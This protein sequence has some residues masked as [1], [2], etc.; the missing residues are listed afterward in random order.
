MVAKA[1]TIKTLA[2]EF[3]VSPATVSKAL[4]DS[5]DISEETKRKIKKLA[6]D[7]GYKPNLMARNLVSR[8]SNI[9]GIIVPNISTS[10]FG[11]T[12]RGIN[13]RSRKYSYETIILVND[14]DYKEERKNIEFLS[15]LQVEGIIIDSVPGDHNIDLLKDLSEKGMP[16]VF[17]DRK[18]DQVNAESVTTNDVKAGYRITRHFLKNKKK[19]IIFVGSVNTLSVADDRFKGYKKALKEY[20]INFNENSSVYVDYEIEEDVLKNKIRKFV[21]SGQKF[22]SFIC[23]GGVIAYN[24]GL[25][26]LEEGYSIPEDVLLGE[27]GDNNIVH[28]LGVPFVTVDQFP[29]KIGEKAFDLLVR[30]IEEP[31]YIIK[32][33]H[34]YI[35]SQLVSHHPAAHEHVHIE[36]I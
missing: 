28:R 3:N 6:K 22:D 2:K 26:L 15:N 20:N 4:R 25:V 36:D 10:F 21:K 9:V 14:E 31:N 29:S 23:A 35:K 12:L 16:I 17:I 7:R 19:N 8:K 34:N 24:V 1:V 30:H 27:F 11:F 33:K 32:R 5:Y 18:C 13:I